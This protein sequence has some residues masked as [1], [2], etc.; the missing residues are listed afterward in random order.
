MSR[1][2]FRWHA[3]PGLA[4][5]IDKDGSRAA[6]LLA[7]GFGSVEFGSVLPESA[8][9]VAVRLGAA[10]DERGV[11][12]GVG[13]G[14]APEMPAEQLSAAWLLGLEALWP[15]PD[16]LSFNLS[17]QAN[18]RFLLPEHLPRLAAA[19]RAVAFRR[20]CLAEDLGRHLP[21]A[22]KLP[23]GRT[24]ETLPTAALIAAAAGF[25]LLTVVLPEQDERFARLAELA[26]ELAGGPS[27]VAVGGIRCAADI[28][29]A[30]EAGAAGV[31][32]HRLFVEQG[33]A[34][35]EALLR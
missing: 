19:C 27:V 29:A 11:A 24:G 6:E 13:L 9:T 25:D 23:L 15:V 8:A 32:V 34:C 22:V 26:G 31:Q 17:A 35:L 30:R 12:I 1:P 3:Q 21:L 20:D 18:R 7:L 28:A 2:Y 5:G 10:R 33:P 16:Y 14:L 4:G